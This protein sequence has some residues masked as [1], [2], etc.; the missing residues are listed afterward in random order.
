[1]TALRRVLAFAV[2][3]LVVAVAGPVWWLATMFTRGRTPYDRWAGAR[4]FKASVQ[5]HVPQR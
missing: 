3:W 2:D 1:M 5:R 4:V